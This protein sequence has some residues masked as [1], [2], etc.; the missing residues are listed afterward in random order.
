MGVHNQYVGSCQDIRIIFSALQ[1]TKGRGEFN[2]PAFVYFRE[3]QHGSLPKP[4]LFFY[5]CWNLI[6][7]LDGT[8]ATTASYVYGLDLSQSLQ[9]AGGIGGILAR[10]DHGASKAH[11]Y[12]YDANGNVGQL[13][14]STD[15][16]VA[17]A[18]EYAPFGGLISAMGS[19]AT[20]NPFR[21][22]SKYADDVTDLYYYGYRYYSPVVERWLS[23][24]PIGEEGG[25][26]L[27]GFVS[28]N[29]ISWIDELGL[30]PSPG[31][32]DQINPFGWRGSDKKNYTEWFENRFPKTC[33][34]AKQLLGKRIIERT[35]SKRSSH[36]TSIFPIIDRQGQ[37]DVYNNMKRYGDKPQGIWE[38][39]VKIGNFVIQAEHISIIWDNEC[40]F[41]YTATV[42]V[43][44]NTGADPGEILSYT[45]MFVGRRVRMAEWP[46]SGSSCCGGGGL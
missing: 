11:A 26:N 9:G 38:R 12:F 21:F 46:I 17:A 14:D 7:E 18:Y 22:S 3:A 40:C 25:L 15:G 24:D 8:G 13:V 27:Y 20:T 6:E 42:F 43:L 29:S 34:G 4:S 41:R 2:S 5:D 1:I 16:S 10:I 23:R 37:V 19:Y 45:K 36:P 28:N 31:V 35:C 30:L 39:Y 33:A 44:E 32:G